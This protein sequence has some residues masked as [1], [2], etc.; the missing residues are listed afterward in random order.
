MSGVNGELLGRC[1]KAELGFA[2]HQLSGLAKVTFHGLGFL[3]Y[4]I[5]MIPILQMIVST[6][7]GL[8]ATAPSIAA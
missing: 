6:E 1:R 8:Q 7:S 3:I 4:K 5:K 2:L